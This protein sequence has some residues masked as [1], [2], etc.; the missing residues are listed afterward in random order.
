MPQ[1]CAMQND[2][3]RGLFG[4]KTGVE[5]KRTAGVGVSTN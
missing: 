1:A 4:L 2:A 5:Q 3:V